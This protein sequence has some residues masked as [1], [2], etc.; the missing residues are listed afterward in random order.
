M[1]RPFDPTNDLSAPDVK[2][3]NDIKNFGW[4]ITGIFSQPNEEGPDWAFTIGLFHSFA[5]SEVILLGLP[6]KTS[7]SVVNVAGAE[8]KAGKHYECNQDYPDILQDPYLCAFREV[9]RNHYRDYVGYALW[10]YEDDSFPLLQCFW[11]DKK[12]LFPWDEGCN[13]YVKKSQPLLF[14]P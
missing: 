5:H 6:F 4:H 12:G 7:M 2:V 3:L 1:T 13:D 14:L 9:H 10:F 11:P 8:V